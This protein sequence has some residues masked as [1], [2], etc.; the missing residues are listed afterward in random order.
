[1]KK[2]VPITALIVLLGAVGAFLYASSDNGV[3]N[4]VYP[5]RTD[6]TLSLP[7]SELGVTRRIIRLQTTN[8][9][10]DVADTEYSNGEFGKDT[11]RA[12]GTLQSR[13]VYYAGLPYMPPQVHWKAT[14]GHD[15]VTYMTDF[16]FWRDGKVQRTGER[17]ENGDY[18][19]TTYFADGVTENK[20]EVVD[21]KGAAIMQRIRRANGTLE[22]EGQQTKAK[23]EERIFDESGRL[24]SYKMREYSQG[25]LVEYYP[26]SDVARVEFDM[27][28]SKTNAIYRAPDGSI[29]QKRVF[30]NGFM[31]TYVYQ[32]GAPAYFQKWSLTNPEATK[33]EQ[34]RIYKLYQLGYLTAGDKLTWHVTLHVSSGNPWFLYGSEDGLAVDVS[35]SVRHRSFDDATGC[36]AR[37][38]VSVGQYG[39]KTFEKVYTP[40]DECVKQTWPAFFNADIP[41]EVPPV[42][43]PNVEMHHP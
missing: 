20:Y 22:R 39:E 29:Q 28:Y 42:P 24:V 4:D 7:G 2:L 16:S 30:T 34:V 18:V 17:Q 25:K 32:N 40:A 37:E 26:N 13:E 21:A 3:S 23:Y 36:V 10:P 1:M 11:Y 8:R 9:L 14:F 41:Y 5:D 31:E 35:K 38:S 6:S 19:T 15:G 12:D 33:P 27:S 43:V